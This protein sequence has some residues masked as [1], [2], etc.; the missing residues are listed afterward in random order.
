MVRGTAVYCNSCL[1]IETRLENVEVLFSSLD[2]RVSC[3]EKTQSQQQMDSASYDFD[4]PLLS[5]RKYSDH[6][7]QNPPHPMQLL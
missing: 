2:Y 1:F 5:F 7:L 6:H 3:L 4:D